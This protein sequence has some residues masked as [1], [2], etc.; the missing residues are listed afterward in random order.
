[1]GFNRGRPQPKASDSYGP[2]FPASYS[3]ECSGCGWSFES[4]EMI[5]ADGEGGWLAECC[6][7]DDE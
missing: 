7:K 6:G 4:G 5:R 3:G 1:M 2:W